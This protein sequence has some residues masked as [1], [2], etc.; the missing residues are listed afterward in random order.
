MAVIRCCDGMQTKQINVM[1]R[2]QL[3]LRCCKPPLYYECKWI[4]YW[5]QWSNSCY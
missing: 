1:Y 4:K 3:V 2:E 5:R